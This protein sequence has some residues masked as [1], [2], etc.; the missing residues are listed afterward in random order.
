MSVRY[1]KFG[2]YV[3]N[4]DDIYYLTYTGGTRDLVDKDK[5]EYENIKKLPDQLQW[6]ELLKFGDDKNPM[7]VPI[8]GMVLM[9]FIVDGRYTP[10]FDRFFQYSKRLQINN[11]VVYEAMKQRNY[12][13]AMEL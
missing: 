10:F 2:Q 3:I 5:K 1:Q 12:E 9:E 8:K 7:I 6:K 4:F 11:L 13:V